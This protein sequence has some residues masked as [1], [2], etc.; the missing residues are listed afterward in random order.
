MFY[1][2]KAGLS[3]FSLICT[4]GLAE[5]ALRDFGTFFCPFS[6]PSR[7]TVSAHHPNR[8]R[9]CLSPG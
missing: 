5:G 7:G 9:S 2:G 8:A 1:K 3:S 6:T 4:A